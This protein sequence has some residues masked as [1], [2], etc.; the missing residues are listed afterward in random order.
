MA[1]GMGTSRMQLVLYSCGCSSCCNPRADG[2][3][4]PSCTL[5]RFALNTTSSFKGLEQH[6][7]EELLRLHND[8]YHHRQVSIKNG[9]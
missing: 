9:V 3:A 8:Y 4:P 5:Q 6:W 2:L 1:P 7:R